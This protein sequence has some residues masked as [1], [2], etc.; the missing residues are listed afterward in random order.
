MLILKSY[1][2]TAL[3]ALTGFLRHAQQVG[4]GAAF[5]AATQRGYADEVFGRVPC[6]CLRIPTGG[7]KTLL[8]SHAISCMSADWLARN[9]AAA[10]R[11]AWAA[12]L[13][14]R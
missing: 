2:Q 14:Q 1:Q 8:A 7:G 6:V 10:R 4:P 12:W 5:R 3:D 11:R 13:A 9:A